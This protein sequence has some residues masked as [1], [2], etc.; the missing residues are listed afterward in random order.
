M[1]EF[2]TGLQRFLPT[3]FCIFC[4]V[5]KKW[6]F[7]V[8]SLAIAAFAGAF[9]LFSFDAFVSWTN[10]EGFCISCHEMRDNVYEEY[11]E[12]VHFSNRSGVRAICSDCHV[13]RHPIKKM[14]R[15]LGLV[16][17]FWAK[18]TGK[19]DTKEKFEKNRYEMAMI[20]WTRMKENDSLE[21][22]NCHDHNSMSSRH[23]TEKA[24]ARHEKA[25]RENMTCID[26]HYAI[27]HKEPEGDK[28][29]QDI[30]VKK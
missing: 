28:G 12:T 4:K 22:R 17:E 16:H 5:A 9:L 19:I 1:R 29:P 8:G 25:K 13:P 27:S 26:C 14:V 23:Q 20:V 7:G 21:C 24:W 2:L 6:R 15:K 18:I 3:R 10:T 30:V 11:R